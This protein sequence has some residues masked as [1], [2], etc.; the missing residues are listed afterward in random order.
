MKLATGSR[1]RVCGRRTAPL[2][3]QHTPHREYA[4]VLLFLP[5]TVL[6]E[7]NIVWPTRH[8][9][10]LISDNSPEGLWAW[11]LQWRMLS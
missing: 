4:M 6:H 5:R 11:F 2:M 8:V 3:G 10:L 9:S 7:K 1:L